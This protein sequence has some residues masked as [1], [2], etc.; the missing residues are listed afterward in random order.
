MYKVIFMPQVLCTVNCFS[1]TKLYRTVMTSCAP[2]KVGCSGKHIIN[3]GESREGGRE[4]TNRYIITK[5]GSWFPPSHPCAHRGHDTSS[6]A[7]AWLLH[8]HMFVEKTCCSCLDKI[9]TS[10]PPTVEASQQHFFDP[11]LPVFSFMKKVRSQQSMN[12]K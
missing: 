9:G 3:G 6:P 4:A 7:H 8:A 10:I 12:E 2:L 11:L 1:F 5:R